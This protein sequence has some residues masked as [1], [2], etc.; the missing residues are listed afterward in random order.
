MENRSFLL[1]AV[2]SI[3]VLFGWLL[4]TTDTIWHIRANSPRIIGGYGD[5]FAYDGIDTRPF[6][7]ALD[8]YLNMSLSTGTLTVTLRTTDASGPLKLSSDTSLEGRIKLVSQIVRSDRVEEEIPVYGDTGTGGPEL[9]R[10]R[11]VLAGWSRFDLFVE[12]DLLYSGLQGEW[13]LIDALRRADGAI[14]QSGLIYSPL[15]RDKT[16]F[17]DPQRKEFILIVHSDDSDPENK[18]SFTVV[19][20]LVFG[21]VEIDRSPERR[22]LR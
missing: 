9:P 14:R 8:L 19:L 4:F 20:H 13:A 16:G 15:L 18:P 10:T 17:S 5:H 11:A 21:E 1:V 7:G 6:E 2:L 12:E 22:D 3:V